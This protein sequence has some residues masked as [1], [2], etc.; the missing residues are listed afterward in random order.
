MIVIAGCRTRDPLRYTRSKLRFPRRE[1][2]LRG[3]ALPALLTAALNDGSACA[4]AHARAETVYT[5]PSSILRLI[6]AFH[7][8]PGTRSHKTKAPRL[9]MPMKAE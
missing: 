5:F 8:I 7:E 1:V 3:E 9:N 6:G 2:W 4:G